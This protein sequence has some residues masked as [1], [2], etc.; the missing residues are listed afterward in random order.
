MG[1]GDLTF[2]S[3]TEIININNICLCLYKYPCVYV[4]LD[5]II[6]IFLYDSR[7]LIF[8]TRF[9]GIGKSMVMTIHYRLI[10][11]SGFSAKTLGFLNLNPFI[12]KFSFH[13]SILFYSLILSVPEKKEDIENI[14]LG[15]FI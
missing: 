1:K 6:K 10:D 13:L 2:M 14:E 11:S 15:L 9:T 7:L 12:M 8:I 5:F 3:I 4:N